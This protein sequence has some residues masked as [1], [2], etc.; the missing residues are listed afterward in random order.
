MSNVVRFPTPISPALAAD[1]AYLRTRARWTEELEQELIRLHIAGTP[2]SM[3]D[4]GCTEETGK[5]LAALAGL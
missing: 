1:I 3:C 5:A 2:P 4:F